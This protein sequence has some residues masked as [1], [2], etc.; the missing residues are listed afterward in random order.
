[1]KILITGATGFVGGALLRK[2]AADKSYRLVAAVRRPAPELSPLATCVQVGNIDEATHWAESLSGVEVV[3]HA[4]ARVHVMRERS[5]DPLAEFRRINTQGTLALAQQASNAGVKRFIFISS[6][7]ANG[8]QT[9]ERPFAADDPC[10][11]ASPYGIS[12]YEAEQ[13]LLA[14]A[15]AGKMEVVILRPPLIYGLGTDGNMHLL[16]RLLYIGIPLPFSLIKNKRSLVSLENMIDVIQR[17][18]HHPAAANQ[19]FMVSD[20]EDVSTGGLMRRLAQGLG[21][22][23]RLLPVPEFVFR[24]AAAL[25]GRPDIAVRIC[26][27]LQVDIA[28]TKELLGWSPP[29]S[30]DAGLKKMMGSPQKN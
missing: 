13:G 3:I 8:E 10:H 30:L 23:P 26:G 14:I 16:Q 25:I 6:V 22:K 2:L 24:W 17:C 1:M 28:K 19:I 7:K 9:L 15:R 18:T 12:K 21:K 29:V 5:A 20:G 4:A 11:P 27:S